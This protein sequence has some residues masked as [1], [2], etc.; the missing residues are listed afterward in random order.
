MIII[1]MII[2]LLLII[3][4]LTGGQLSFTVAPGCPRPLEL[5]RD[6]GH[7]A[8]HGFISSEE[9]PSYYYYHELL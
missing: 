5:I 6:A 2:L 3:S 8:D 7:G 1:M 9:L 4:L